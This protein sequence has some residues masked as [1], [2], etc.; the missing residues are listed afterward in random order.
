VAFPTRY[1]NPAR[2]LRLRLTSVIA[3]IP[4]LQQ[5]D[6]QGREAVVAAIGQEMAQPLRAYTVGDEVVMPSGVQIAH[7]TR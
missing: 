4:S 6:E 2:Y 5:L 1:P 7:A 3:A